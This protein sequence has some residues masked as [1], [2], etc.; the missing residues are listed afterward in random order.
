MHKS[1]FISATLQTMCYIEFQRQTLG[2]TE[3]VQISE[4]LANNVFLG[5]LFQSF[6]LFLEETVCVSL[7]NSCFVA[8]WTPINT[9]LLSHPV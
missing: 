5:I 3:Q 6:Y 8:L 9:P 1:G 4:A 2:G 7:E